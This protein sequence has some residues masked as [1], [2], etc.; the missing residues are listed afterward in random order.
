LSLEWRYKDLARFLKKISLQFIKSNIGKV[1]IVGLFS[2]VLVFASAIFGSS[3]FGMGMDP[4]PYQ[5][6]T[7]LLGLFSTWDAGQYCGIG[8]MGY[9]PGNNP[10]AG[11]WAWFPLYPFLIGIIGRLFFGVMLYNEAVLLAGFLLSNILFFVS[12]IFFY[13]LTEIVLESKKLAF[14]S[15]IFFCLWPGS[16]FY[17]AVY[18]ES[19]FMTL[20]LGAF[21]FLEKGKNVKSTFFGFLAAFTR[22]NGFLIAIPFLYQGLKKQRKVRILVQVTIV[23][24]PYLLFNIYGYYLTGLFPVQALVYN[25]INKVDFFLYRILDVAIDI[26]LSYA[27]LFL[28][29]YCLV[30]VPF[31]YLFFSKRLLLSS[32]SLGLNNNEK[33]AKYFGFSIVWLIILLFYI[34]VS[35]IH[36]Y[37]IPLLPLYWGYSKIWDKNPKLGVSLLILMIGLLVT[38]TILY[39]TWRWYW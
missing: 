17:S 37:A 10:L 25:Q 31:V 7:P 20:T 36:R 2:R 1:L 9:Q 6:Q 34:T 18:S 4:L 24:L 32:F 3:F 5:V 28:V 19:L 12:L 16:L 13:K 14:L 30:F 11:C 23:A 8:S 22:S 33:Q 15:S 26:N 38:G 21:Y 35:N 27:A 39:S 29:E